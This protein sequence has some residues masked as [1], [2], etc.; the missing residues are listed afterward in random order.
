MVG[1][2]PSDK[3]CEFVFEVKSRAACWLNHTT[4]IR[5][6]TTH[7]STNN[8]STNTSVLSPQHSVV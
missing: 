3:T 7:P 8:G 2:V 6:S 4:T 5:A 1:G